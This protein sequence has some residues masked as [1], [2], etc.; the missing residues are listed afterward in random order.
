MSY[1]FTYNNSIIY[2]TLA[3]RRQWKK[4]DNERAQL[5]VWAEIPNEWH[6]CRLYK[7]L[8]LNVFL[9][10]FMEKLGMSLCHC[11]GTILLIKKC[12]HAFLGSIVRVI[13]SLQAQY[14]FNINYN[15]VIFHLTP[16]PKK[17]FCR[18]C[19]HIPFILIPD[20]Y[21]WILLSIVLKCFISAI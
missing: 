20:I 2:I 11:L 1:Y 7:N 5:R 14:S 21:L 17:T 6:V 4:G 13:P 12:F 16:F 19:H 9:S 18:M 8:A 15:W 10:L 3:H